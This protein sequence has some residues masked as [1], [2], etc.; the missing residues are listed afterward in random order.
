MHPIYEDF[1]LYSGLVTKFCQGSASSA[2]LEKA[3][4]TGS[5][6]EVEFVGVDDDMAMILLTQQLM[7]AQ[8]Y[9]VFKHALF[10]DK[11]SAILIEKN[12]IVI[13]VKDSSYSFAIPKVIRI[14]FII[15]TIFFSEKLSRST[16]DGQ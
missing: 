6:T 8:G 2:S 5:S 9:G 12:G 14:I 15:V 10:Q 7:E 1:Q 16:S 13:L 4:K 3:F 11:H